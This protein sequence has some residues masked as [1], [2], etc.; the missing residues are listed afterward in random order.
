MDAPYRLGNDDLALHN[1]L[2]STINGIDVPADERLD[3]TRCFAVALR[4]IEY[5]DAASL[6]FFANLL[7]IVVFM[8]NEELDIFRFSNRCRE[9][10]DSRRWCVTRYTDRRYALVSPN[11]LYRW[12]GGGDGPS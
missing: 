11:D 12:D 2:N 8:R 3:A 7:A 10:G 1:G 9:G 6:Q 5:Y 4:C